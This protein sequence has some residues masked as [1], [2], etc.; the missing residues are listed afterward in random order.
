M[1]IDGKAVNGRLRSEF[2]SRLDN[3]KST[4]YK[5]NTNANAFRGVR[6]V[7]ICSLILAHTLNSFILPARSLEAFEFVMPLLEIL[8]SAS[9]GR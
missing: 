1:K 5:E 8:Q 4:D 9:E 6:S 2:S 3:F 7:P